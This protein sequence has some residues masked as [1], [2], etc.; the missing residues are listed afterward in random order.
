M[1]QYNSRIPAYGLHPGYIM[2]MNEHP[3]KSNARLVDG[4]I[5]K[6]DY[7]ARLLFPGTLAS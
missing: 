5:L 4:T 6:Q 7:A 2:H 3:Q 1:S